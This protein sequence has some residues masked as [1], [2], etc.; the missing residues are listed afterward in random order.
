MNIKSIFSPF[1]FNMDVSLD[2]RPAHTS[3]YIDVE[4]ILIQGSMSQ[5]FELGLSFLL[6]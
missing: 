4:N 3:F 6:C 2:I 5:I 1:F